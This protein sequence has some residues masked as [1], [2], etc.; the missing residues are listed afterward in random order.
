MAALTPEGQQML[1]TQPMDD[2]ESGTVLRD[3]E[4]LL[5]FRGDNTPPV[6]PKYPLLPMGSLAP[7]NAQMIR[8][9]QLGLQRP[10]QRAYAHLH[11]LYLWSALTRLFGPCARRGC[12]RATGRRRAVLRADAWEG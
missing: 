9:M 7:L 6:S 2:G 1:C 11:A 3:C 4:P 5:A 12:W 10:H 8:P